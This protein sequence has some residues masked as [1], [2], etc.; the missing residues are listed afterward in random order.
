M[1]TLAVGDTKWTVSSMQLRAMTTFVTAA[2][3]YTWLGPW[4]A[5]LN[6]C[7]WGF[8]LKFNLTDPVSF[9]V[10]SQLSPNNPL[11]LWVDIVKSAG[12]EAKQPGFKSQVIYLLCKPVIY[13]FLVLFTFLPLSRVL[14][15]FLLSSSISK[16]TK[17][18]GLF[19]ARDLEKSPVPGPE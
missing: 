12:S 19:G 2:P 6:I 9:P 16:G 7:G 17:E 13:I 8:S 5:S 3:A 18:K 15:S 11:S 14:W 10:S 4:K 1:K